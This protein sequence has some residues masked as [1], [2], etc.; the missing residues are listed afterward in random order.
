MGSSFYKKNDGLVNSPYGSK[1][2]ENNPD[3]EVNLFPLKKLF[4]QVSK[5]IMF[6]DLNACKKYRMDTKALKKIVIEMF[7]T[8]LKPTFVLLK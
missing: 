3:E 5:K 8:P 7:Y 6:V 1:K 2:V 4:N